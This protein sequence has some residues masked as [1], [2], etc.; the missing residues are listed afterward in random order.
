[1]NEILKDVSYIIGY[2]QASQD[3]KLGLQFVLNWL[4]KYLPEMEILL[5]EQ[6]ATRK[7]DVILPPNC[8]Y[9]FTYN[10]GLYNRCWAFNV[11]VKLTDKKIVAFADSDLFLREDYITTFEAC[12]RF[13]AVTPNNK[14][15]YNVVKADAESLTYEVS[16]KRKLWTFAGGLMVMQG[17][18][19]NSS[20]DGMSV[21][22]VGAVKMA[23]HFAP[24]SYFLNK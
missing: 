1:M 24:G 21:L 6:D 15:L 5:L 7:I 8:K 23:R 19:F 22:K 4:Y 3:R 13:Q 9:H 18:L 20:G 10:P 14:T 17:E 2:R 16:E 11:G 12:N